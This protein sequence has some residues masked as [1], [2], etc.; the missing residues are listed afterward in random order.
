MYGI[1]YVIK[2]NVTHLLCFFKIKE[3]RDL[4]HKEETIRIFDI[5]K[6]INNFPESLKKDMK[7][8]VSKFQKP[9][10]LYFRKVTNGFEINKMMKELKITQE[11]LKN[12]LMDFNNLDL[13]IENMMN[14]KFDSRIAKRL[15]DT[16]RINQGK[17]TEQRTNLNNIFK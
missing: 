7:N 3:S 9:Y 1:F 15:Y 5:D 17:T 11:D 8:V 16:E 10:Q 12:P 4:K 6:N 13:I 14:I 2:D